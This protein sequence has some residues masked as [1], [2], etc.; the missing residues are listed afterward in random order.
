MERT[1]SCHAFGTEN[2]YGEFLA[3]PSLGPGREQVGRC[4]DVNHRHVKTPKGA[5]DLC[6]WRRVTMAPLK[7]RN[8]Q[9][10]LTTRG[11]SKPILVSP[12]TRVRIRSELNAAA[13]RWGS[14][15]AVKRLA[16]R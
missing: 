3:E 7:E 14:I 16:G 6:L 11:P 12:A 13:R 10:L 8:R 2:R 1:R 9:P 15:D 4:I 5:L